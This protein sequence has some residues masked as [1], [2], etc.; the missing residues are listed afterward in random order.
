MF[1]G[2]HMVTPEVA[3]RIIDALD[4]TTAV[5]RMLK[6]PPSTVHSWRRIGMKP[7]HADHLRLAAEVIGKVVDFSN[8][9]VSEQ[10]PA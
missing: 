6:L 4:G 9:A 8:G 10:V 2:M 3:D 1:A 5:G 7:S